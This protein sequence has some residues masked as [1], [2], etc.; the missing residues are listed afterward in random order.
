M[1]LRDML[2]L[3]YLGT[4]TMNKVN[5]SEDSR[6]ARKLLDWVFQWMLTALIVFTS[7]QIPASLPRLL[8]SFASL[9]DSSTAPEPH[10]SH[11]QRTGSA[12]E[13]MFAQPN[14]KMGFRQ[15]LT[16]QEDKSSA[17]LP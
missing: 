8:C 16:A 1:D 2:D 12:W 7:S 9:E 15:R 6:V 13:F 14:P 4:S 11:V 10:Y 5:E 3:W 17:P